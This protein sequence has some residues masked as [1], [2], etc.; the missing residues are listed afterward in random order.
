MTNL[1]RNHLQF[2]YAYVSILTFLLSLSRV[3]IG[4]G[5]KILLAVVSAPIIISSSIELSFTDQET[6]KIRF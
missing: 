1:C 5:L 4:G 2:C 6:I 3:L